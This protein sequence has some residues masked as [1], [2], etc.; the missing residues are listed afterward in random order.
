M[1]SIDFGRLIADLGESPGME[2]AFDGEGVCELVVRGSFGVRKQ[3]GI[4]FSETI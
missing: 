4:N 3:I 2:L 1:G